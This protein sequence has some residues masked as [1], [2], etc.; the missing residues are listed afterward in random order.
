[1][2]SVWRVI[3]WMVKSTLDLHSLILPIYTDFPMIMLQVVLPT[4][5]LYLPLVSSINPRS[6][7]LSSL[8]VPLIWW[9]GAFN[10]SALC[11]FVTLRSLSALSSLSVARAHIIWTTFLISNTLLH[12][13]LYGKTSSMLHLPL[14]M[15]RLRNLDCPDV[16]VTTLFW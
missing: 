2:C 1:M 15:R 4:P 9:S 10:P 11:R 6:R 5:Q 8:A 3:Q 16:R 14:P 12:T 7:L 13:G